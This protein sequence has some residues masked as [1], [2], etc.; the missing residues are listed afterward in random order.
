MGDKYLF[1]IFTL[2]P[3]RIPITLGDGR[4]HPFMDVA[5]QTGFMGLFPYGIAWFSKRVAANPPLSV[6]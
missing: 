6:Y 2:T 3:D 5:Q 1:F 4:R